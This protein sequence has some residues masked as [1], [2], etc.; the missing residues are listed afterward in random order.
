MLC[1]KCGNDLRMDCMNG[2][3]ELYCRCGWR[4]WVTPETYDNKIKLKE[5]LQEVSDD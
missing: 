1:P 2:L 5:Y 3:I 4:I